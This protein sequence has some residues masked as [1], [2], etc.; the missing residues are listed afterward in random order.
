MPSWAEEVDS[1]DGL[2]MVLSPWA[3]R[4]LRFDESLGKLHGYDFDICMQARAAGKKVATAPFRVIHRSPAPISDPE[5]WIQTYVR[6]A[7]KWRDELP[8]TG[9]EPEQRALRAEAEAA[10]ESAHGRP[11]DARAGGQARARA[12]AEE[13]RA[14]GTGRGGRHGAGHG[15]RPREAAAP[16][17][18]RSRQAAGDRL[19]GREAR[20]RVV[21]ELGDRRQVRQYAFYDR[22]A[23]RDAGES[24]SM[25]AP[26]AHATT[27]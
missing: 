24:S 6:L 4:E 21:R 3:V 22:E 16:T 14:A 17:D 2:I 12:R 20:E 10:C 1:I 26:R 7:E 23:D 19:R 15:G 9:A 27:C 8:D 5:V 18:P 11:P 25:S 13:P